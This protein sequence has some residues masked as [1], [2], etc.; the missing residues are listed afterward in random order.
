[1]TLVLINLTLATDEIIICYC[2]G[3]EIGTW[4]TLELVIQ[5]TLLMLNIFL[6]TSSFGHVLFL[7]TRYKASLNIKQRDFSYVTVPR[8]SCY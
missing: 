5:M 6:V 8:H 2:F 1:M 4:I 7:I 3:I